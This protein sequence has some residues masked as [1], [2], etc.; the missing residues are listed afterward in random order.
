MPNGS[1]DFDEKERPQLDQFFAPVAACLEQFG[2]EHN[3]LLT[4]YWHQEP[5]WDFM[6]RHPLRGVGRIMIH[7]AG[8][9]LL[10]V[11]GLWWVDRY[12]EF[13]RY[14]R[15]S[16]PHSIEREPNRLTSALRDVFRE[17]LEWHEE[18]WT[19]IARD[20]QQ[21]W[22]RASKEEFESVLGIYPIPHY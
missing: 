18:N 17:I 14:I 4:R 12:V 21:I 10:S 2:Q 9:D 8:E 3:L 15:R 20:Y 6:F 5:C 16:A 13:T 7:K 1:P 22:S 19:E 11:L